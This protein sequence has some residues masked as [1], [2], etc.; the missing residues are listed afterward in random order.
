MEVIIEI[1]KRLRQFASLKRAQLNQSFFKTGKGEY[2]YGDIFLGI[3][4]PDCRKVAKEYKDLSLAETKRVIRSKYHE[5]RMAG[6][7][8]LVQKYE[9]A[10]ADKERERLY[11]TYVDHFNYINNWD[12]VDVTCPRIVGQHLENR[13]RKILYQWAKSERLWTKRVAIIST[14]WFVKDGDLDDAFK[15][16]Q[17]LLHDEHDLIHK[18]VGWVLREAGK[19]EVKRLEAFL[20]KH[21][22]TMPRT[23]LRYAIEK[24]PERKRQMYLKGKV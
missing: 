23:M 13:N 8:I 11:K 5:E 6:L 17:V 24:F 22:K 18:A 2:G 16:A 20:K 12:L 21:C 10:S 1:H 7:I 9:K 19:K 3:T 15:L 4:M 14:L